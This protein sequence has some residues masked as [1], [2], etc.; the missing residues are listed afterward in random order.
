M[1]VTNVFT[2]GKLYCDRVGKLIGGCKFSPRYDLGAPTVSYK[3]S[4]VD[5]STDIARVLIASK[6]VT[7]VRDVCERCGAI[8]ER[9]EAVAAQVSQPFREDH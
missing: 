1:E 9:S 8:V 7:Y 2:P 5:D 3:P 6:P 4:I